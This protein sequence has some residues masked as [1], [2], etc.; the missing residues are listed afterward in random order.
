MVFLDIFAY[1]SEN[2]AYLQAL[3]SK[4]FEKTL[5]QLLFVCLSVCNARGRV[6]VRFSR[7]KGTDYDLTIYSCSI[8][9]R[10]G[11]CLLK[12]CHVYFGKI[13]AAVQKP[14]MDLFCRFSQKNGSTIYDKTNFYLFYWLLRCAILPMK[15]N[16]NYF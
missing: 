11:C 14:T 10:E 8:H 9:E 15:I 12:N 6:F 2:I 7:V 5:S 3:Y 4:E 16:G 13:M 1:K